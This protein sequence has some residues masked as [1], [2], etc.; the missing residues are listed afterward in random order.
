M[1]QDFTPFA[2]RAQEIARR[3]SDTETSVAASGLLNRAETA[4]AVCGLARNVRDLAA[5]VHDMARETIPPATLTA[6]ETALADSAAGLTAEAPA[7]AVPG[8]ADSGWTT[9]EWGE[10]SN[11][12]ALLVPEDSADVTN[13]EAAQESIITEH[14]TSLAWRDTC[15]QDIATAVAADTL[16]WSVRTVKDGE[17]YPDDASQQVPPGTYLVGVDPDDDAENGPAVTLLVSATRGGMGDGAGD[18]KS[19][20]VARLLLQVL[21]FGRIAEATR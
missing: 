6:V 8:S 5:V 17:T 10:W 18:D 11:D 19:G 21:S 3:A 15:R 12:L 1:T 13:P 4:A 16:A 9:R 20:D 7:V 2:R 14:F